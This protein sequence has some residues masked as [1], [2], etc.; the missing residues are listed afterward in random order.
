MNLRW[1]KFLYCR[2]YPRYDAD[3]L[4]GE[5]IHCKEFGSGFY[6]CSFL[7]HTTLPLNVAGVA[8]T[9]SDKTEAGVVRTLMRKAAYHEALLEERKNGSNRSRRLG[10]C[11]V[12]RQKAVVQNG[13]LLQIIQKL[14]NNAEMYRLT[15]TKIL[16][17]LPIFDVMVNKRLQQLNDQAWVAQKVV[18]MSKHS[19]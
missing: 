18:L 10:P 15:G 19:P 8:K 6:R 17:I 9:G 14:V 1:A 12:M 2:L 5:S 3:V 16:T 13:T 4:G 7:T 11:F